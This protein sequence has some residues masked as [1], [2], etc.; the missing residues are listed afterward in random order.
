LGCDLG[1]A[2][3]LH[4]G[5]MRVEVQD[6]LA[7]AAAAYLREAVHAPG[8]RAWPRAETA[9]PLVAPAMTFSASRLNAY[10]KCPRR[11]FFDYLCQVL[12][13]TGS[14]HATYGRVMH[15]ALEQLHQDVRFPNRQEPPQI[16]DRLLHALDAAFGAARA[17]F[18]SQLEY[19]TSR[20]RAR[21]M[22]EQYVRWLSAESNR[23]PVEIAGV[24]IFERRRF[25]AHDFIG[26]IDRIDK[27]LGGGPVTIYDYKT[28]RIDSDA[29]AYLAK[30]RAGD[31]AQLALY[32]A[33]RRAAGDRIARIALVSLRDPR[34]D[35]WILALDL[36]PDGLAES[37][38][39]PVVDG[40]LR[41]SCSRDDL[42]ASL[43]ALLQRCDLLTGA[44]MEHFNAGEDPPCNYCAYARACRDR[45][46]EGER[47]FAR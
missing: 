44:G 36:L 37:E 12:E 39:A 16:L 9:V 32:Y 5:Q 41:A 27:P 2:D 30:I 43:A 1:I 38:S 28:G 8:A 42:D 20:W 18:A 35:V 25:G 45:P 17:D 40:V 47:A 14:L 11:F 24:E 26:Y 3:E 33:M 10:V 21:R 15:D 29:R 4:R 46:L 31:E 7:R 34:D 13:D 23:A 19:E 6:S 22:A